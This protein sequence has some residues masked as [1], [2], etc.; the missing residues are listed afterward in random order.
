MDV[1]DTAE[2]GDGRKRKRQYEPGDPY[3]DGYDA[4]NDGH[5]R[6]ANPYKRGSKFFALWEAGWL[7]TLEEDDDDLV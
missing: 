4:A 7:R 3:A 1:P 2:S 6:A 5:P